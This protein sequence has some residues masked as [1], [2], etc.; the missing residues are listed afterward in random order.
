M[1]NLMIIRIAGRD[2]IGGIEGKILRIAE[3]LYKLGLF[4]PMLIT[5]DINSLLAN[6]FKGLGF[7]VHE[8][9]LDNVFNIVKTVKLLIK[10]INDNEVAVLQ[11]H[12][13]KES[14]I[15]RIIKY[16]I[17]DIKHVFRVHVHI[18]DGDIP[19]WKKK[20]YH[21]IDSLTS[22]WVDVYIPISELIKRQL[23]A[24]THVS[25]AKIRVVQNGV[26]ALGEP[27]KPVDSLPLLKN[28]ALIADLREK[29]NQLSAVHAVAALQELKVVLHLIGNDNCEYK[30]AI[31]EAIKRYNLK[32]LVKIYGY[33]PQKDIYNIL[34]DIPVILLPSLIE[35]VPTSIIE[36]MSLRK[37]VVATAAG[38]TDEL[39][40]DGVNGIILKNSTVDEL[41][42]VI[43][44]IFTVPAKNWESMRNAGYKTWKY[45][46]SLDHMINGLVKVYKEFHI[47]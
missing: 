2:R 47:V 8:A 15:G 45:K 38:A 13:F 29:K 42:S 12:K 43:K 16:I 20:I 28:I 3:E 31:D 46:Y 19:G 7:Y 11:T 17:K 37:L 9:P 6:S 23:I 33:V 18:E 39:I 26:P 27:D 35:G 10:L 14:V 30:Y 5:N 44:H 25:E 40:E 24:F 21:I 1:K 22:H 4:K 36:G 32:Q 41:T 34:V